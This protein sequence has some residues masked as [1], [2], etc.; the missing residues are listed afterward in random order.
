MDEYIER[1]A[2]RDKLYEEDAIT[3]R[4]V[5]IL[6]Q[7]PVSDVVSR[8]C[9][10]RILAEN[11]TMREQLAAIGKKPGD[12]MDDVARVGRCENLNEDYSEYDQFVCLECGIELQEWL[13]IERD[14]DGEETAYEYA[15]RFCPNC[16]NK[17]ENH[18]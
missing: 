18:A 12:A 13:R 5:A 6:N 9:Y 3:M 16:G 14:E 1:N 10:D 8:D 17:V 2:I 11:D 15:F 7:F 4:G